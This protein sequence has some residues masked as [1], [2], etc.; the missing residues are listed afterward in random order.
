MN[1][2][3]WGWIL[4]APAI[5]LLVAATIGAFYAAVKGIG[6]VTLASSMVIAIVVILYFFGEFY[7][8]QD[9]AII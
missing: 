8:K 3:M 2:R 1:K 5:L 6:G 9:L 4:K 7:H